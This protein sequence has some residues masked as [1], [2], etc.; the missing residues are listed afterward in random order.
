MASWLPRSPRRPGSRAAGARRSAAGSTPYPIDGSAAARAAAPS[1][2]RPAPGAWPH[3]GR[4]HGPPVAPDRRPVARRSSRA[5]PAWGGGPTA[6]RATGRGAPGTPG[7]HRASRRCAVALARPAT[8]PAPGGGPPPAARG[9]APARARS[10]PARRTTGTA[11]GAA[12]TTATDATVACR[13][14]HGTSGSLPAATPPPPSPRP[15]STDPPRWTPR[16]A[17]DPLAAPPP[18]APATSAYPAGPDPSAADLPSQHP[19]PVLRR[20]LESALHAAVGVVDDEPLPGAEQLVG[21]H[22]RAQRV[23]ARP[24]AGVADHVRVAL[25]EPRELGRVQ[26][27]VHAGQ[28]REPARW[29]QRQPALVAERGRV[30]R[31]GLQRLPMDQARLSRRHRHLL[32]WRAGRGRPRPSPAPR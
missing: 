13:P 1:R 24:A 22:E 32:P 2:A 9:P 30:A 17:A 16:T 29:R 7:R 11:P 3:P 15:R 28:D 27:G 8:A 14:P 26:P 6:P 5:S 12:S 4:R 31:V 18:A 20:P 21:D 23:V 19:P 10:P 25:G